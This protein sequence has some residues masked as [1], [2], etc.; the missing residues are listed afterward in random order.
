MELLLNLAWLLLAVPAWWLWRVSRGAQ[1]LSSRQCLLTLGCVL[2]MLFPV[3]SATDDLR[4]VRAVLEEPQSNKRMVR[5]ATNEKLP[6]GHHRLLT[7]PA[8]LGTP[9]LFALKAERGS[10]VPGTSLSFTA[11]PSAVFSGR[12]P[13]VSSLA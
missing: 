4:A 11:A 12:A 13:P 10:L 2:V 1:K 8:L 7:P 3:V 5:Q 6:L 9:L